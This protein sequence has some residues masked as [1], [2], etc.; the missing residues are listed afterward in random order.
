VQYR[1]S[2]RSSNGVDCS[3]LVSVCYMLNGVLIFRDASLVRGYAMKRLALQWDGEGHFVHDN[4]NAMKPGD[5][6]YL[7]GH[8]AMYL[9]NGEYI[10]STGRAGDNG[11]VIN[12]LVPGAPGYREDLLRL[13]YAVGGVRTE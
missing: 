8:I 7:P 3:G 12:S 2:G 13:M 9:G 5:A 11:V 6:L 4:L 10:H 1:W